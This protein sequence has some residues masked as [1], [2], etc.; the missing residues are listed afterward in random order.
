[1]WTTA[2]IKKWPNN[3][4]KRL[5]QISGKWIYLEHFTINFYSNLRI[6]S[7]FHDAKEKEINVYSGHFNKYIHT[8]VTVINIKR[9]QHDVRIWIPWHHIHFFKMIHFILF[10]S[11]YLNNIIIIFNHLKVFVVKDELDLFC[12]A[13]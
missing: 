5:I 11:T 2:V 7:L 10:T 13:P 4:G 1:M 12:M 3:N 6:R 8:T 9:G